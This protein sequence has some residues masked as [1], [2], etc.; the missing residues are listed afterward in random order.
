MS[1]RSETDER[2]V[3]VDIVFDV[4]VVG[5]GFNGLYQLRRLRELD[6]NVVLIDSGSGP[7]GVWNINR[8]PG[9]RTDSS[10]PVYQFSD[11]DLWRGWEFSEL[12]PGHEEVRSYFE[13]V[14]SKLDLKKDC[15]YATTL[16]SAEFDESSRTWAL[17]TDSGDFLSTRILIMATGS[18]VRPYEPPFPRVEAFQGVVVHSAR[19][20]EGG[21]D[22]EGKKVAVV[23]TGASGLQL[24]QEIGPVA[25]RLTVFQRTP[26]LSPPMQQ[27]ELTSADN[28]ELK[29]N[30]P[31]MFDY[32]RK[33]YGGNDFDF[34]PRKAVEV[35]EEAR[36]ELL[37]KLWV[38]GG[39][40]Y[41]LGTFSDM[42]FD[43]TANRYVYDFWK[44]KIREI[45]EDPVK[46]ELLAPEEPPHAFGTKR[47]AL[48][49]N[50]YE[51]MNQ[52]NVSIVSVRDNR[53]PSG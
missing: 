4:V 28:V 34:D 21:L 48:H 45:V 2:V 23:G 29:K 46:A 19:W 41:Y 20:P 16:V 30:Y 22:Y 50:Y 15:R 49:Q 36:E 9:A 44:M 26:N 24:V 17:G 18:T 27:R 1:I 38:A 8:Y 39:F 10:G 12:F 13:Y 47:P 31:K 52:D 25:E 7:G 51:V 33:S 11:E 40:R 37:G 53:S 5:A 3:A 32:I 35:T 43:E 6:F 42:L 14:E